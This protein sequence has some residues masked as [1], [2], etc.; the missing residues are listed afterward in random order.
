MTQ[1]ISTPAAQVLW[2]FGTGGTISGRAADP[3]DVL[4][5][6]AGEVSV[7]ALLGDVA[8][9][10][11]VSVRAEQVAQVDSKD[12][13]WAIWQDL[14]QRVRA[15]LM[16][17]ETRGVVITHGTDTM[18]ETAYCLHR[19]LGPAVAHKA[20]V[21]TGAMRPASAL[22]PDGPGNIADAMRVAC[23]PGARGVALC[24]AGRVW[25]ALQGQKLHSGRL[26]AFGAR[27]G[28]AFAEV[29]AGEVS[30]TGDWPQPS[31]DAW[32]HALAAEAPWVELLTSGT[33]ASA[34]AL[35]ALISAGVEGVVLA[36]TGNGTV[37]QDLLRAAE[38]AYAAGLPVV[39]ASRT[40]HGNIRDGHPQAIPHAG[41]LSPFKARVEMMLRLASEQ[42]A[43]LA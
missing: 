6:T 35:Q 38:A 32:A 26:D 34:R 16:Q 20:V 10:D 22:E 41:G 3:K 18:E 42:Q 21:L 12:M 30:V 1:A 7:D 4:G 36:T 8:V 40:A 19:V 43:V 13:S 11:G 28:E 2:V 27:D 17:P 9:P 5:Y 37:H 14:A 24:M 33:Q 31:G 25:D 23:A 15:A 39:R 29:C